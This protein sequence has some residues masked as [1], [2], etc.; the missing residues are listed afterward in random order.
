MINRRIT[1]FS[2]SNNRV[3]NITYPI[4]TSYCE[5]YNYEFIPYY[6]NLEKKYKP[7]WNKLHY[8]IKL[9]RESKS[10]YIVWFDHDIVIKNFNIKLEDIIQKYKFNECE[11]LLMMS[12]DP[13]INKPFNSG[14]IVFFVKLF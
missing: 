11:A 8:S 7:H 12:K 14:V 13:V 6:N 2:Y 10:D 1:C 9:L 4:I 5:L 3:Y